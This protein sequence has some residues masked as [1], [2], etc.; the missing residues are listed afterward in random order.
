[1]PKEASAPF[2][3]KEIDVRGSLFVTGCHRSGTSLLAS[4]LKDAMDARNSIG[5]ED[6]TTKLDNPRGFFESQRLVET[7]DKLLRMISCSWDHPPLLTPIWGSKEFIDTFESWREEFHD[8]ALNKDWIDKD[9]RLCIT[10]N[11]YLH[12]LLKRIP[13]IGIVRKPLEVATSLYARNGLSIEAGL[14]I[15]YLYNYHLASSLHPEDT[16]VFYEDL[17]DLNNNLK[18]ESIFRQLINCFDRNGYRLFSESTWEEAIAKRLS[19]NLNRASKSI[20]IN[21]TNCSDKALIEQCELVYSL[22]RK[23]GNSTMVFQEAFDALPRCVLN[24]LHRHN[25]VEHPIPCRTDIDQNFLVRELESKKKELLRLEDENE[26][27]KASSSWKMTAPFRSIKNL[28][29]KF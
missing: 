26:A 9:P 8:H 7:N 16:V 3:L 11:A 6:L 12:I 24:I 17:L 22:L 21:M 29:S 25:I 18:A 27:I 2:R 10:Y 20:S 23:E 1:M 4:L 15:W 5:I 13:I 19:P 28:L 14:S